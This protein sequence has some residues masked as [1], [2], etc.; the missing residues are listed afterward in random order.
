MTKIFGHKC[1]EMSK[2]SVHISI[3]GTCLMRDIFRV[4][5]SVGK[6]TVDRYVQSINPVSAVGESPLLKDV[7]DWSE[8]FFNIKM[9]AFHRRNA[10]LDLKKSLFDYIAEVKSNYLLIDMGEIRRDLCIFDREKKK[11]LTDFSLTQGRRIL[12]E[13]YLLSML[14]KISVLELDEVFV[15]ERLDAYLDKILDI[16]PQEKIILFEN[17]AIKTYYDSKLGGVKHSWKWDREADKFNMCFDL[18]F[19]Y[20]LKKLPLVKVI[21]F[22]K[23]ALGDLHHI[24]GRY[25]LHYMEGIYRYGFEAMEAIVSGSASAEVKEKLCSLHSKWERRLRMESNMLKW[26]DLARIDIKNM[27]QGNDVKIKIAEGERCNL[28]KPQWFSHGG[29]GYVMETY[30]RKILLE[31]ECVGAGKL[32]LRLQGID[33]CTSDGIRLPFWVNYTR[34]VVNGEKIFYKMRPLWHDAPYIYNRQVADGEKMRVEISW[35]WYR[36]RGDRLVSLL[37]AV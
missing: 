23:T 20:C 34:L 32:L 14:E 26:L 10:Y 29:N 1:E 5:D 2:I 4:M 16:Y 27:G 21:R 35:D 31:L 19:S 13:Q 6:Y 17:Y 7:P 25:S 18:V 30:D 28:Y 15:K 24:W 9:N 33:K 3:V 12:Q 8:K 22:P 36:Y 37:T 11:M